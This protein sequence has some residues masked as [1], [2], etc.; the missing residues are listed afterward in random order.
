MTTR[1]F[2]RCDYKKQYNDGYSLGFQEGYK[3]GHESKLSRAPMPDVPPG[4]RI[5]DA[6]F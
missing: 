4:P 5:E 2:L 6:P 3:L 1:K